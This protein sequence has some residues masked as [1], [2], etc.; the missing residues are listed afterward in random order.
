MA[1]ATN[2]SSVRS[3]LFCKHQW[4]MKNLSDL[5]L[6]ACFLFQV[7]LHNSLHVISRKFLIVPSVIKSPPVNVGILSHLFS[8][9]I[10]IEL[11][12][13]SCGTLEVPILKLVKHGKLP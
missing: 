1:F 3:I 6:A 2:T 9:V 8:T 7:L 5:C 13:Q 10:S 11:F 12:L 4:L